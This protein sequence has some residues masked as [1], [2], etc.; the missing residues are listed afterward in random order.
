[1]KR[2]HQ[3]RVVLFTGASCPWCT[4]VKQ[5][6]RDNGIRFREVDASRDPRAQR[7]LERRKIRGVPV[8]LIKSQAIVGF[9]KPKIDR[10]LGIKD[11][12]N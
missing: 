12:R 10:L 11:G 5:Y 1:V 2:S 3:P 6:L 8:L 7:E 4:R 9:D